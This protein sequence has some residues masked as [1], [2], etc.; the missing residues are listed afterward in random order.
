MKYERLP[1]GERFNHFFDEVEWRVSTL[2]P[3]RSQDPFKGMSGMDLTWWGQTASKTRELSR[4]TWSGSFI[5]VKGN[6]RMTTDRVRERKQSSLWCWRSFTCCSSFS[7][8]ALAETQDMLHIQAPQEELKSKN[9]FYSF[10]ALFFHPSFKSYRSDQV[11][12]QY[13]TSNTSKVVV[14]VLPQVD[15]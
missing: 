11:A 6:E 4:V 5:W 2:V 7:L 14:L 8:W 1:K 13:Y 3:P 9:L 12:Q 15:F 10:K